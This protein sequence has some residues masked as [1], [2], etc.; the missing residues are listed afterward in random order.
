MNKINVN[1]QPQKKK[2][3]PPQKWA[4]GVAQGIGPEFEPWY[5]KKKYCPKA[6]GFIFNLM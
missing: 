3:N 4:V 2:K 1:Y 6:K 5:H